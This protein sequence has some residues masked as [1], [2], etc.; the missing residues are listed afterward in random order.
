MFFSGQP[1]IDETPVAQEDLKHADVITYRNLAGDD[2]VMI[3][4]PKTR[5]VKEPRE[6]Q[7]FK[8]E[9]GADKAINLKPIHEA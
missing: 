6:F 8:V 7:K 3:I 9:I 5:K 1:Y 2:G 4:C